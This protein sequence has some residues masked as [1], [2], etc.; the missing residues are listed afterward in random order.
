M[1]EG[2]F[3]A[4]FGAPRMLASV[5]SVVKNRNSMAQYGTGSDPFGGV[6]SGGV[7]GIML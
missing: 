6:E 3:R 1:P 5:F 2:L 4:A 7:A